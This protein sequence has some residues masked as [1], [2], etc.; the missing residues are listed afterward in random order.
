MEGIQFLLDESGKK[1]SVLIDL[2]KYGAIWED[3][4]DSLLT[5]QRRREPREN[6]ASVRRRLVK[7]GKL[8]A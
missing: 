5:Q 2:K 4:Y 6:L 3:V 8:S 1:R 7:K